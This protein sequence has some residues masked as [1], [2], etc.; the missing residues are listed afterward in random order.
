MS[1]VFLLLV[2]GL[3]AIYYLIRLQIC[4][5]RVRYLVDSYGLDR[6]KLR[7]LSCKE[8]KV[9]R[10]SIDALRQADDAFR[11]ED[12]I[13]PYRAWLHQIV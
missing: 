3:M 13:K 2:P 12:L 10:N 9:L 11:L 7:A 4:L 5:S 1:M 6:Q 8:T